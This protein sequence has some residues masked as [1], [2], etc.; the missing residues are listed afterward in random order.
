MVPYAIVV[1]LAQ[2]LLL[3]ATLAG[4]AT[5]PPGANFPKTVSVALAD[6]EDTRLGG[7][8]SRAAQEHGGASGFRIVTAGADGFL[9][10]A[11][12]IEASE[13]TLDLQYFIFRGD[14][15]GRLLT[16]ALLRVAD[17]RV[18][19]RVLVDD[20]ATIAGDEQIVRR[21]WYGVP[22]RGLNPLNTPGSPRAAAGKG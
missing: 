20:G 12:M 19:V 13:R 8:F 17:R 2:V 11:Q 10:R 1:R 16:E 18:R 5:L 4:C 21:V 7:K 3:A 14:E 6:P 15:T 22:R 9:I